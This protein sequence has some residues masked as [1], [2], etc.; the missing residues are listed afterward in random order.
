MAEFSGRLE[1]KTE[2][3]PLNSVAGDRRKP[4]PRTGVYA[5]VTCEAL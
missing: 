2:R 1:T 5:S 4:S 3:V